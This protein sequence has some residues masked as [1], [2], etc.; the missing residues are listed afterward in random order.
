MYC[1]R[2]SASLVVD[3][4][5]NVVNMNTA[6]VIKLEDNNLDSTS[7]HFKRLDFQEHM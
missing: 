3:V 4:N 5:V 2:I 6:I 1:K 7:L